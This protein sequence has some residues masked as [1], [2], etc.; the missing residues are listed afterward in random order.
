M[1]EVADAG[2][3]QVALLRLGQLLLGDFFEAELN[4]VVAF[5]F[6]GRLRGDRAG[7]GFDHSDRND[8]ACFIEDLRHADLFADDGFF[9]WV[10]LL[11]VIGQTA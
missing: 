10:F 6:L 2:F 9:H 7:A 4:G 11:Q 3:R 1:L 8:L 5:L